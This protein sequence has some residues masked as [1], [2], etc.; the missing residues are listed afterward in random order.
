MKYKGF[1]IDNVRV[2]SNILMFLA[3]LSRSEYL[4]MYIKFRTEKLC[5]EHVK[6]C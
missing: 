3:Q 1:L 2:L 4:C 5:K 6:Y